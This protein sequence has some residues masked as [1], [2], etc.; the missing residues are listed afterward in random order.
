MKFSLKLTICVLVLFG[1]SSCAYLKPKAN[2]ED[3]EVA[4]LHLKIGTAHIAKGNYPLALR[5]LLKAK[6]LN[7]QN[8]SIHN[9]LGLVYFAMREK[10]KAVASLEKA[11]SLNEKYTDARNN[12]ARILI[13]LGQ[14][15]K[16]IGH[17]KIVTKDLLYL[18]PEKG[19]T[20]LGLA[21]LEAGEISRSQKSLLHA[22][23]LNRTFCPA[24]SLYGKSLFVE[25]K[26]QQAS[27]ILERAIRLCQK[28]KN[29]NQH[30]YDEPLYYSALSHMQLGKKELTLAKMRELISVYPQSV[31][32][33]K[34][35]KYLD[36]ASKK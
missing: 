26:Y 10:K 32:A 24:H 20:N 25:K 4:L 5:E 13:D 36:M 3:Q 15:K 18:K 34:A 29:K 33:S 28:G 31:Y 6:K 21:Y 17:L 16:A 19:W 35:Q 27:E 30:Q 2:K 12:L 23:H 7:P 14:N 8:P 22:I 9:N 1:L 11:V